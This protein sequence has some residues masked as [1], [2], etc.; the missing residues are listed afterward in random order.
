MSSRV[1]ARRPAVRSAH[2][3]L[4]VLTRRNQNSFAFWQKQAYNRT[5]M[6]L[7]KRVCSTRHS[8]RALV[9]LALYC[10]FNPRAQGL[11]Q[12]I[13]VCLYYAC[14]IGITLFAL[15]FPL[16]KQISKFR[17]KNFDFRCG[18]EF[19]CKIRAGARLLNSLAGSGNRAA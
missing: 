1:P 5:A 2:L 3:A 13:K 12:L 15:W 17:P 10:T 19:P 7:A 8:P 14:I 4:S 16:T 6:P 9:A 18:N 11:G